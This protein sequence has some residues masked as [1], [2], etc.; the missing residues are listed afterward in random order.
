MMIQSQNNITL[1][2][3]FTTFGGPQSTNVSINLIKYGSV[4]AIIMN[5]FDLWTDV[6][7][8]NVIFSNSQIIP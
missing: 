5:D 6:A 1:E 8:G 3:T 7:P 2:T 4:V